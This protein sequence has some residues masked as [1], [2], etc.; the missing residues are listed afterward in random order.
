MMKASDTQQ[1]NFINDQQRDCLH[2][3]A[4]LPAATDAVPFLRRGHNDISTRNCLHVRRNVAR[5]LHNP[6]T[7]KKHYMQHTD[8]TAV[9]CTVTFHK[10]TRLTNTNHS[11]E[12]KHVKRTITIQWTLLLTFFRGSVQFWL[13]S[14]QCVLWPELSKVQYTQPITQT[15]M[16][17][18][19]S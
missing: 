2:I 4:C 17:L 1:V 19:S 8:R 9:N 3:A 13:S 18:K 11:A 6:G 12:N 15:Q 16:N 14:L 7:N 5:Q 10:N